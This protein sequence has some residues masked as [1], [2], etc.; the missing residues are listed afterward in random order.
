MDLLFQNMDPDK[1]DRIINA[2]IEEFSLYPYEKASTN[3]IVNNAGISKGLL[4]HY[5]GN[6]QDL[7]EK[8]IA[9]VLDKLFNEITSKV[10]WDERDLFERIKSIVIIKLKVGH[11][12]PNMFD[13]IIKVL[14]GKN[15]NMIEEVKDL[16]KKYG[17]NIQDLLSDLYTKNIDYSLFADP[18]TVVECVNVIRWTM[19]K[20][21]EEN[22][23]KME[24]MGGLNY[25]KVSAE[26]DT[27]IGILKK[28]FYK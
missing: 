28:T 9:F 14:S 6:K 17:L 3:N 13:F 27:Y 8:L 7:Y 26:L 1:K 15:T 25:D 19:E 18:H 16:Y 12:Y 21:A 24:T 22:F 10:E 4:F 5:F 23:L 20:Y 11:A 2:A